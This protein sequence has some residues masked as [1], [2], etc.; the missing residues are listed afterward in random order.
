MPGWGSTS[1]SGPFPPG[2][3]QRFKEGRLSARLIDMHKNIRS[4]SIS[5]HDKEFTDNNARDAGNAIARLSNA[6]LFES[7]VNRKDY[8]LLDDVTAYDE[9]YS[10]N[11][12]Y[13]TFLWVN[14]NNPNDTIPVQ[15]PAIDASFILGGGSVDIEHSDVQD[16][17]STIDGILGGGYTF[18]R[19]WV[20]VGGKSGP[21]AFAGSFPGIA[22]PGVGANPGGGP[23]GIEI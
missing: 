11:S 21:V 13:A 19:V 5:V 12:D 9:G 14:D 4:V 22:E 17:I 20:T 6:A 7:N 18:A 16:F 15:V 10:S 8:V 1:E 2:T 23:G 3:I